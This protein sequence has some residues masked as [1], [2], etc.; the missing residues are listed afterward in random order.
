MPAM[1]CLIV[2][3][4]GVVMLLIGGLAI[5]GI[6]DS[7]NNSRTIEPSAVEVVVVGVSSGAGA[8][9]GAMYISRAYRR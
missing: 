3:L 8:F 4:F 1:A 5:I 6:L 9:W 7:L 2:G